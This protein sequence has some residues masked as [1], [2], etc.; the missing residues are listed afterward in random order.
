MPDASPFYTASAP[1]NA[2]ISRPS[3]VW[4]PGVPS[5]GNVFAT[6]SEIVGVVASLQGAVW[7]AVDDS[8]APAII[9][10]GNWDLRPPGFSGPVTLVNGSKTTP[11]GALVTIANAAVTI[12]GLTGLDGLTVVN[13]STVDVI[14]GTA[15]DQFFFTLHATDLMQSVLAAGAAF[16][17]VTGGF[18]F[19]ILDDGSLLDTT[20]GGSNALQ[21][22]APG[23]LLIQVNGGSSF[24]TNELSAAAGAAQV[25]VSG[26]DI[27]PIVFPAYAAQ[28]AAPN[29]NPVGIVQKGSAP[30]DGVS[31]KTAAITA[32]IGPTTRIECTQRTSNGDGGPTP[33]TRYAALLP[34][35]VNGNP[36]TFKISALTIVGGGAVNL[37]DASDVD[38][39]V[40]N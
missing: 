36:G 30:I 5:V 11:F 33:T 24:G 27:D 3:L 14:V 10:A 6:W 40:V 15:V 26:P 35:R 9:P 22:V 34:D 7:V 19:F 38:W 21:S 20:D 1:S 4:R 23:L 2:A 28:A 29:I 31:G 16:I 13:Q 25:N 12:H 37:A 17:K 39:E 32:F 8:I 18:S